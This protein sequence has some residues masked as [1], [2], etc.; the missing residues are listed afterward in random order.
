MQRGRCSK[1]SGT[2][3]CRQSARGGMAAG[4][5]MDR[6]RTAQPACEPLPL[7][8]AR[9][10][11]LTGTVLH[12]NLGRALMPE[13]AVDAVAPAMTSACNL[14]YDLD[15][16]RAASATSWSKRCLQQLTGAEAATVV[17]NNAAAVLLVLNTPG[18]AQGGDRLAR[19]ADRDR[20]RV[21]HA[22]HHGASRSEAG[23]GRHH[24]SHA[25]R[26]YAR[27]SVRGPASS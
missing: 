7:A 14:E 11:N 20:R 18:A 19:R 15:R 8:C 21:P 23:R 13:E 12:T 1:K 25:S 2:R 5:G 17:N 24:Q 6:E 22:R 16:A 27:R 3:S 9:V 10:F 26:D 4:R